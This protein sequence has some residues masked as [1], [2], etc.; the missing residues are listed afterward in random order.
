MCYI[1]SRKLCQPRSHSVPATFITKPAV[2]LLTVVPLPQSDASP[3]APRAD[4]LCP[5]LPTAAEPE[6][7]S[8]SGAA[9]TPDA[10]GELAFGTKSGSVLVLLHVDVVVGVVVVDVVVLVIRGKPLRIKNAVV[11]EWPLPTLPPPAM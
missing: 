1:H 5:Q 9:P 7:S 11:L 2:I 3:S 8:V 6:F 10:V 4:P